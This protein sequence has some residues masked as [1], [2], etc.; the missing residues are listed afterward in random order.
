MLSDTDNNRFDLLASRVRGEYSEM[1]GLKLTVA[2]ACRLWQLDR[3]TCE[4][5]LGLLVADRFLLRTPDGSYIAF[6]STRLKAA[7]AALLSP[8]VRAR[9]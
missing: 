9:A 1:P 7:K 3:T 2:Q 4:Y 6:P 5:L 8:Y